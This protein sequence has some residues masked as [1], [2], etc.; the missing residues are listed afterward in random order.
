MDTQVLTLLA[1][2]RGQ[3][4]QGLL[5]R[6]SAAV[7]APLER[8]LEGRE[9]SVQE[10][11]LLLSCTDADLPAL[12]RTADL[13]RA[14]RVG[15]AVSFVVTRNINFT[16]VCYM[17][18]RFCGFARKRGREDAYWIGFDEIAHRAQVAWERGATEVCIQGGLHP[19]LPP[20]YYRDVV[21]A[22]KAQVPAMHVH[23]FSPFEIWFGAHK[24]RLGTE[25]F[26]RELQEAGLG[27]I[28]G[29][30]A[31]I[32][33]VE[34][35]RQ[36]TR[37]KL[38]TQAWVET[39]RAAHRIGLRST[40]TMMYGH[41]DSPRHWAA[42]MGLLRDIQKDT[43]GFTEFVPLGFVHAEAPLYV[44]RAIPG[45]RAGATAAEHVRVHA[46]A[47][48]MLAGWI[49][50]IQ[51]SWVKLGPQMG[52]ALLHAGVND[53]GGTLM[54]ETIS[55]SAG[56]AFGEELT[57]RE[58]VALARDAGRR[59]VRR[60]TLYQVLEDYADHEPANHGPL[61]P[62]QADPI[63]FMRQARRAVEPQH[64]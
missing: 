64:A 53:L 51:V 22:V 55:R 21:R 4:I 45:V 15:D 7:R 49:D 20:T 23:A 50:N 10:G 8:A 33:D 30:A 29:T 48:L 61:K 19:E 17:G 31:E 35:R 3:D 46:V 37:N 59:P 11:E 28:P 14:R 52:Q 57:P 44:D 62:R 41:I 34:I 38:T 2:A 16:N 32:L 13:V 1:A 63:R 24:R 9:L 18:C 36:L 25:A 5:A 58:M 40:S 27:S 54:D 56:A 26:L 12:A 39:V 43:G 47:R 6:T 42:H 60:G